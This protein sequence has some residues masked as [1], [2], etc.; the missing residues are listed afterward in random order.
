MH[1]QGINHSRP[2]TLGLALSPCG[3]HVCL[4]QEAVKCDEKSQKLEEIFKKWK[5]RKSLNCSGQI[6]DPWGGGLQNVQYP[7]TLGVKGSK[8]VL[9]WSLIPFFQQSLH[10]SLGRKEELKFWDDVPTVRESRCPLRHEFSILN[11][12]TWPSPL[13][14]KWGVWKVQSFFHTIYLFRAEARGR[15]CLDPDLGGMSF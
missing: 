3:R 6:W 13:H 9:G 5:E 7:K 4:S 1:Y 15:L 8:R 10:F 2:T 12:I 14:L 11:R